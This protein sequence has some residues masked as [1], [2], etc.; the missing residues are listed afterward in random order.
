M[1]LQEWAKLQEN[2]IVKCYVAGEGEICYQLTIRDAWSR[3]IAM[4]LDKKNNPVKAA[5]LDETPQYFSR[6]EN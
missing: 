2:A 3:W 1:S 6:L 5:V 4:R